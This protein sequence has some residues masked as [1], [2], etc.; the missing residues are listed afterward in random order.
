MKFREIKLKSGT[1]IFL[2]KNSE[3]NDELVKK[4]RGKENIIMHTVAS[5]SPFCVV[6]KIDPT[7]EEIKEAGI[8]CASKSQDWRDHKS[9]V[10]M[11][12][13]TGKDIKKPLLAKAGTWKI[14]RKADVVNIKKKDI[15]NITRQI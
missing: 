4:F 7:K 1:N 6:E 15:E 5:G 3:N 9:D 11:H 12:I 8:I 10:K 14:T 2:G 13:F